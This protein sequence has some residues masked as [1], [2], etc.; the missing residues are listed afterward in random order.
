VVAVGAAELGEVGV[1]DWW[2]R[3]GPGATGGR[4]HRPGLSPL[5][6]KVARA[7]QVVEEIRQALKAPNED[8]I[9]EALHHVLLCTEKRANVPMRKLHDSIEA[10]FGEIVALG[11][12]HPPTGRI[13]ALN[14]DWE[15]LVRRGRGYRDHAYSL[16]KLRFMTVNPVRTRDGLKRFAALGMT[17]PAKAA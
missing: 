15:A 10:H 2:N 5:N 9:A 11:R 6:G 13:E 8:A 12:H 14:N 16:A 3:P 4:Q 7:Y 1:R 17:A